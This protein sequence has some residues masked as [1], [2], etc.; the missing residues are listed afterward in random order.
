MPG[1]RAGREDGPQRE[2]ELGL[3]RLAV[4]VIGGLADAGDGHVTSDRSHAGTPF[5]LRYGRT[6]VQARAEVTRAS[7]ARYADGVSRIIAFSRWA[8][9]IGLVMLV[10]VV[11]RRRA[12]APDRDPHLLL[13]D[14]PQE[15]SRSG[16]L[17]SAADRD[18]RAHRVPARRP[19][20]MLVRATRA[21]AARQLAAAGAGTGSGSP[22]RRLTIRRGKS[23]MRHRTSA[24]V[25]AL[26][27]TS[28]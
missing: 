2:L 11:R 7:S 8:I 12:Q 15:R 6:I 22:S 9:V 25:P 20:A 10:N 21:G 26:S 3:G 14:P 13:L 18:L 1:V 16:L 28:W 23:G 17:R 24:V 4:L 19:A 27:Q 5:R